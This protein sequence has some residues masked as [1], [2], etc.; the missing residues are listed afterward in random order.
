MTRRKEDD[1]EGSIDDDDDDDDDDEEK[2]ESFSTSSNVE[3]RIVDWRDEASWI[4][5][6]PLT[7]SS[8]GSDGFGR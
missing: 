8:S 2:E 5:A 1:K 4:D 6:L 7:S 3:M